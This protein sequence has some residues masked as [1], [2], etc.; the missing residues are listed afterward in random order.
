M[1]DCGAGRDRVVADSFDKVVNC[2]VVDS[3]AKTG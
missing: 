3:A 1:V 2:E